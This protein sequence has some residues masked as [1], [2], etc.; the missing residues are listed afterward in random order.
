ME[1]GE[2]EKRKR[3][4]NRRERRRKRAKEKEEEKKNRRG[5]SIWKRRIIRKG[6]GEGEGYEEER[7]G[8]EVRRQWDIERRE[9]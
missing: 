5:G 4:R 1:E 2:E 3:S 8:A 9:G 6:I 7:E